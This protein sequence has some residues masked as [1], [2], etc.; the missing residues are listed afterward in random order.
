MICLPVLIWLIIMGFFRGEIPEQVSLPVE[1][2]RI[3]QVQGTIYQMEL[4][5]S[6]QSIYLKDI[7]IISEVSS[8]IESLPNKIQKHVQVYLKGQ[9][10]LHIGN[11][12]QVEGICT[13]FDA[14]DNPG[15]FDAAEYYNIQNIGFSVK[16]A[17]VQ[18]KDNTV[19]WFMEMLYQVKKYCSYQI[20]RVCDKDTG[21]ILNAMLLGNKN[22]LTQEQ[23]NLFQS[24]GI[25]HILAISGLHI[26]VLGMGLYKLL[27][28]M[29]LLFFSSG[30]IS[31]AM[32]VAFG[33]MSGFAPS[34]KR[35][36][37]M[38]LIFL[39]AQVAGRTYD[40][41]NALMT[42]A[43][44]VL[45]QNPLLITQAGFLLS[46]GAVVGV[47][48]ADIWWYPWMKKSGLS[49][50]VSTWLFTLPLVAWF[51]YSVPVAGMILNLIVLP[52][53]PFVMLSGFA[54]MF[55]GIFSVTGGKFFAAPGYYI[56]EGIQEICCLLENIPG[57][58][59]V[60]GRPSAI[61]IGVYYLFLLIF[62]LFFRKKRKMDL[63]QRA[64]GII[65]VI[66]ILCV[67]I[68]KSWTM[69]FLNVGQGD[70][71]CIRM[72]EGSVWMI[73]GGSSDQ[74]ALARYDI[75]P[76]LKY[77]G[78]TRID[79]WFVTHFDLDH[80]SAL[81][82]ILESYQ[83]NLLGNNSN[84]ITIDKIFIP[85]VHLESNEGHPDEMQKKL[86]D[87][88]R[89]NH[90]T[91]QKISRGMV[92]RQGETQIC[93]LSPD[94]SKIY[95]N[96]NEG[97]VVAEICY[98]HFRAL[99]T[100]DVELDGEKELVNSQLLQDVDFLKVAH[101]GSRNGTGSAFLEVT[102]PEAAVISCGEEN[103]Y[104]HPH[105]EVL[106]RLEAARVGILRTDENGAIDVIVKDD[107][108]YMTKAR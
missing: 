99:L 40:M 87:L 76:Y 64:F 38:F 22:E 104:G 50:S 43:V 54:G 69:T 107:S 14:P 90:I 77:H 35:A 59:M 3:I 75:E 101:H 44:C 84:G 100:G 53:M 92:L 93:I 10:E 82:E 16:K 47:I 105:Y 33:L 31:G 56:L 52:F 23:K 67:S 58:N 2:G 65:L 15:G 89:K 79:C 57:A 11:R 48:A 1:N 73:D 108:W 24:G 95:D 30:V 7:S 74:S 94:R 61:Q 32:M 85:D 103:R 106:E 66:T 78:V 83:R 72:P 60:I 19:N 27:R 39:G 98:K 86:L 97:S 63:L 26:S 37:L 68:P 45:F 102:K 34:A 21:A 71:I 13:Y 6:I 51:Y 49:V 28:K 4:K 8:Q 36:V 96:H 81:L 41:P 42:A 12:V 80:V 17:V 46:F 5:H 88:A 18:K 29:G 91:V 25:I 62:C 55:V 20:S 9:E 70:G